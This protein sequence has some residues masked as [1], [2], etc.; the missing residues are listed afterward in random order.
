MYPNL[1]NEY[2]FKSLTQ[3]N[4]NIFNQRLKYIKPSGHFETLPNPSMSF[5][6]SKNK[7]K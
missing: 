7:I 5:P 4:T 2:I 3:V 6:T 1:P